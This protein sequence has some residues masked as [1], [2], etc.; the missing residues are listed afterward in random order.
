MKKGFLVKILTLVTGLLFSFTA[1]AETFEGV[2]KG[3]GGDIVVEAEISNNKL[4]AV[5]VKE[6]VESDFAKLAIQQ[7]IEKVIATQNVS[8]DDVAGA[9]ATSKGIKRAISNAI[10]KSGATLTKVEQTAT[11]KAQSTETDVVVIGGGGAGI[12]AAIAAHEK[13]AKVILLEKTALLGGN[14]NYATAGLNAADT[15]LQKQLG[16]E[17]NT[18]IFID[19]T[20][21]GGKGTNNKELVKVL[22]NDSNDIID[23]LIERGVDITEITSTGGQSVKRTHR[24]TGGTAIG[25]AVVGGLS[26]VLENEKIDVRT[27]DKVVEIIKK[28]NRVVGV[29]V[30]GL[31]GDYI[32]TAKAVIVATG[33]FGAN[34]EMVAKYNSALKGFGTTNSPAILGEGIEM[35]EKV[36]GDLVDMKEIQTHPTVLHKN[37]AM[38]TEAV[39]GEGAI[40]VNID[41]KRFINELETRDVVSKAV[42]EQK[43]KSAFL[44]F[45]EEIREKLKAADGYVKKGYAIEGSL[46]EIAKQTGISESELVKTFTVYNDFVKTKEDKEFGKKQ[47]PRELSGEKFY[48]IE[49]SPA[50]HHTMGGVRINTNAEVLAKN[51]K[52]IRGLYAA[53]EVTGGVHGANRLGGNAMTDITVFGK[54]AGENAATYSKSIK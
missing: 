5:K 13:G 44:I 28:D 17:D 6:E 41:G 12:T 2:G 35:V 10:K 50:V 42:L 46:S 18:Q 36:G 30:N 53:G 3:F 37:T 48:A 1:F 20:I 54:I 11:V 47:L 7:I 24:P 8:V 45:N 22:A 16:I 26:K 52:A 49:I 38:I 19:D 9:T 25:P 43:T 51:G 27:S 34:S 4:T 40:L 29:K 23:W 39:R 32:I 33:G 14:T 31:N 15:K 21:K